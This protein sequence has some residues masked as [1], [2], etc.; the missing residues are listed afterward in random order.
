M[1]EYEIFD[2]HCTGFQ[3][4]RIKIRLLA[5]NQG[6]FFRVSAIPRKSITY[7]HELIN[8]LVIGLA[9]DPLMAQ[10]DVVDVI[11]QFSPEK[12]SFQYRTQM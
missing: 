9:G 5:V 1:I 12:N 10:T 3:G 8:E 2:I 11:E 4:V 6:S 7:G